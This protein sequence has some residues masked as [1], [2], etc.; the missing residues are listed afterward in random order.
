M[1]EVLSFFKTNQKKGRF[2]RREALED[3]L[4]VV[5]SS[6]APFILP[7]ADGDAFLDLQV[8]EYIRTL[9]IF[10]I[11]VIKPAL[12]DGKAPILTDG[13]LRHFMFMGAASVLVT[14]N[15]PTI[16]ASIEQMDVVNS[17]PNSMA[18]LSNLT[19]S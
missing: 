19:S 11:A 12:G 7:I 3:G 17:I 18:P 13:F 5:R 1:H 9:V 4:V 2:D 6:D 10:Q 16:T 14:S 8:D 15:M